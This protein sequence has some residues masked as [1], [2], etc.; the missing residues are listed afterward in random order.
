MTDRVVLCMKW[1]TAFEPAYVNVL[2]NACAANLAPGFRFVCLTD[3]PAGLDEGIE[4]FPIPDIGC[5]HHQWYNGAWPKLSLFSSD[6]HGLTG[7]ALFLDLDTIVWGPL[8]EMFEVEGP[9]VT[10]DSRPWR[11]DDS[12]PPR[13]MTS[14]FAYDLGRY[15]ALVDRFREGESAFGPYGNEQDFLHGEF[16]KLGFGPIAY[17][18]QEWLVS[19]KYHLRQ[20]L[21]LDRFRAPEPPGP[22]VKAI[23]FHGRPRPIDLIRPPRGNWDVF[24]HYGS[25]PVDWMVDYWTRYGGTV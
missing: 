13:T 23:C 24:P 1:G 22:E 4:H 11:Y 17:W 19:F 20:P 10:L 7:R 16:G 9:V 15:G 12:H 5:T 25:G 18:P 21:I 14:I 2:R 6:L 8:D 3:D